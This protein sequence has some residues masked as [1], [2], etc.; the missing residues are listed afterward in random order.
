[1][2]RRPTASRTPKKRLANP[3]YLKRSDAPK[4]ARRRNSSKQTDLARLTRELGE[5]LEQHA[6]TAEILRVISSSPT[7]LKRVFA[8]VAASATRLCDASDATIHQVDGAVLRLVAHHG[9]IRVPGS[10]PMMRGV[11]AGRA[12]LD[13]QTIH[14]ADLQAETR[15][16]PEG[17]EIARHLG[18]RTNLAVP[19]I[20]EG[21]AI[22]V[23]I[24][25]RTEVRPFTDRQIDLLRT[26]ATQAV[27]ALENTRLFK[28]EQA[29][30]R[31]LSESLEQQTAT[32]EVLSVISSSPGELKPVFE[33]MLANAVRLC[34]AS[35]GVLWLKEG[36]AFRA[37]A[38]HGAM[39]PAYTERWADTLFRPSPDVPFA[40]AAATGHP[41][42]I[43]DLRTSPAYLAGDPLPVAAVNIAGGPD[44]GCR[45]DAQE[46]RSGWRLRDL[47]HRGAIVH[48]Q[49]D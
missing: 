1:V 41:V 28:A 34:E 15:E 10:L 45:A 35:Y 3:T 4:A 23:V 20:R 37:V 40:R 6:A 43:E 19:L 46:E 30:T 21:E 27:I 9:P 11:L 7:D 47:S 18:L 24:I 13:R 25:R 33:T 5:A 32:A 42:H 22:G 49:A 17:S 39:P 36:D 48:Q 14:V 29:R 12:V 31:E 44:L 2:R 16:Y 26:F 8:V 38:L